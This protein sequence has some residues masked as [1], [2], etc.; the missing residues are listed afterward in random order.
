[1]TCSIRRSS[2]RSADRFPKDRLW[3]ELKDQIRRRPL[4]LVRS[5][6]RTLETCMMERVLPGLS[7]PEEI[8][9]AP[10]IRPSTPH[11]SAVAGRRE[12]LAKRCFPS[13]AA[14]SW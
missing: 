3:D 10:P 5:G 12:P 1:M 7:S 9:V 2:R 8:I 13:L 4:V 14:S 6:A 11:T